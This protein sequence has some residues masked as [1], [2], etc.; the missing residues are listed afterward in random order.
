MRY[1][2]LPGVPTPAS[3]LGLGGR[4]GEI[5]NRL[6]F[7]LLD[8][9][10]AAGGTVVETAHSYANGASE[11]AIGAW[12]VA[13]GN[14]DRVVIVDKGC[15]PGEDGRSRVLPSVIH[16]EVVRS[17]DRLQTP[18]IDVFLLHR[19]DPRIPVGVLVD[20]LAEELAVGRIRAFGVANWQPGRVLAAN[21]HAARHDLPGIAAASSQFCLALPGEP[22]WP[23]ALS[24]DLQARRM[25]ERTKLPLLA[26]SAQARGWFSGRHIDPATADPRACRTYHTQ[27]NL[28]RLSRARKVALDCGASPT[29]VA[30]AY[31]LTQPFPVAALIGP[32]TV[33]ELKDALTALTVRL[34]E[35]VISY[36]EDDT[37]ESL[38]VGQRLAGHPDSPDRF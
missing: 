13:R 37:R 35:A 6:A 22:M 30:L 19:D 18:V 2:T 7:E 24:L 15:H 4:F 36:L 23:G 14:R 11:R 38:K 27:R 3:V 5:S 31:T 25:H 21:R 28:G 17:L 26:W 33:A 10:V 9:F 8:A 16:Q 1:L 34:P 12:M 32:E 29:A 20:A